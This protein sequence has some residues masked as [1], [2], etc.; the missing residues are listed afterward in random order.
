[1]SDLRPVILAAATALLSLAAPAGAP[2]AAAATVA[3]APAGKVNLY[4]DRWGMPH[5]YAAREEDGYFGLGY[6]AGEDRLEGVLVSYL[7]ARGELAAAF[8]PGP[9]PLGRSVE[10]RTIIP[11]T[12]EFDRVNLRGRYLEEA[13]DNFPRLPAQTRAN[14]T[15]YVSGLQRYMADHPERVPAWAPPL[16]PALPA[17]FY[18]ML[19][20]A[21][22]QNACDGKLPKPASAAPKGMHGS[23]AWALTPARTST[24]GAIFAAD[25]HSDIELFG[26]FFYP[27]RMKAGPLDVFA[28]GITGMAVLMKGHSRHYAWAWTE[29][30]RFVADCYELQTLKDDPRSYRFDGA[31]RRIEAKP[32]RIAVRGAAPVEGEF[33]YTRHNGVL[34]PVVARDGERA[35]VSSPTYAGRAG[36]ADDQM[37]RVALAADRRELEAAL[38]GQDLY[39]A[40]LLLA[41]ADGSVLYI[42]PGRVPVRPA[43]WQPDTPLDG[44]TSATA[45]RGLHPYADKLKLWNPPEGYITNENI[46]PDMMFAAPKLN[47]ADYPA[48][49]GF[50]PGA[51]GTRQKRAIELLEGTGRISLERAQEIVFDD[52]APNTAA[53]AP[54]LAALAGEFRTEPAD[55]RSL[56]ASAGRFDGH[57]SPESRS[58]L[59]MAELR[60]A[61]QVRSAEQVRKIDADIVAGRSLGPEQRGLVLAAA[62][63]AAARLSKAFGTIDL[64]FGDV[65]V[66]GRGQLTAPGRGRAFYGAGNE[67]ALLANY[68]GPPGPDGR[69][70]HYGG[71]RAPFLVSFG[72]PLRSFSLALYGQSD[73]PNSPHFSDQSPLLAQRILKP[74]YFD[75]GQLGRALAS[76]RT[77]DTK[78]PP[79]SASPCVF[80]AGCGVFRSGAAKSGPK[81][82]RWTEDRS[83]RRPDHGR[84]TGE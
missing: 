76:A 72:K 19:F 57:F 58:A 38:Q 5:I 70:R 4:R 3:E 42:R 47:P 43:G 44:S 67:A 52:L 31:I 49:F 69:R 8:G 53:W 66:T 30:K 9:L 51:T 48:Y 6:A 45:W 77:L 25:S 14:L 32:Y 26:G 80:S 83:R 29:G 84:T 37:R 24:G 23:N 55:V 73:D 33:E 79:L 61:L 27:W 54:V 63:D 2:A 35:W 39:P 28:D 34:S 50:Q 46:S 59:H 65:Y 82:A 10:P 18:A 13:R 64:G 56:L 78:S 22:G 1:V 20:H 40:N 16:E 62:R 81:D 15:A 75:A 36:F 11:D 21:E 60:D 12:V 71:T 74:N 7:A 17:A 41:G 68:Y